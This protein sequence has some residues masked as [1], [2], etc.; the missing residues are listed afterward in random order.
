MSEP[1]KKWI[2]GVLS[3]A[4]LK[5]LCEQGHIADVEGYDKSDGPLDYSSLDLTLGHEGYWMREGSVKPFG[6]RYEHEIKRQKLATSL[7]ADQDGAFLLKSTH[8]YL[9]KLKEKITFKQDAHLYGQATAKSTIGRMDVLARLIVDGADQ[10]EGFDPN[11]LALGS[12][13]MY[14]EIT[15]M[16]FNVR[17]KP[18]ISLSQ[19]R[20]FRGRDEDCEI[21]GQEVYGSLLHGE[22]SQ[23][24]DGSLSVDLQ[25]ISISGND[26]CAFCANR[27]KDD[28]KPIDLWQRKFLSPCDYWRFLSSDDHR[29][30]RIEKNRFY[31]LRSKEKMSLTEGVAVYCKAS[32]ESIGEMRIHYAGF[33]HPFFGK[34]RK[35]GKD[36]TPLIFEVR[37]H[38]VNV[39]LRDG[40][41]MARLIFYRMSAPAEV[42]KESSLPE[43]VPSQK[44][45]P[46]NEQTLQLSNIFA[47]WPERIEIGADGTVRN[48]SE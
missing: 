38:D 5:E 48:L 35:D 31:I 12:G 10:Y 32:D 36:G 29:R 4:Q 18:G 8:T 34:G 7:E 6:A 1:W 42:R 27:M 26:G 23:E 15:P 47:D 40:E 17:V 44:G 11:A 33:V 21:R 45:R 30:I 20:L 2:P 9:F 3:N 24:L 28:D 25:P 43:S 16:T 39:N 13:E 14:L 22:P 19:L 37:G 41:K 46:Y